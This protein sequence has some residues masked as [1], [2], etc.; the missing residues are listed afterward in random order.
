LDNVWAS[1][2]NPSWAL[3]VCTT[4]SCDIVNVASNNSGNFF[5][6]DISL[7]FSV[8]V[9]PVV[10]VL[11]ESLFRTEVDARRMPA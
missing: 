7:W 5:S 9:H 1:V 11:T 3:N 10:I 2:K 4:V 8:D 6:M